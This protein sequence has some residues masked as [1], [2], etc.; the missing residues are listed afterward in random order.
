MASDADLILEADATVGTVFQGMGKNHIFIS[1]TED[2]AWESG[3][4]RLQVINPHDREETRWRT[5]YVY[6][7]PT[8]TTYE[9]A[10]G[11]TVTDQVAILDTMELVYGM[12]YRIKVET[13]GVEA[14][15][16]R[17]NQDG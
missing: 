7:P 16:W 6:E 11:N 14:S 1:P 17:Y 15:F 5:V 8:A 2:N 3:N 13:A 12:L 9:D 10:E 4:V